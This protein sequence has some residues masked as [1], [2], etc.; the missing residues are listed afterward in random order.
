MTTTPATGVEIRGQG[1]GER[2][3]QLG[4]RCSLSTHLL[5]RPHTLG[6]LFVLHRLGIFPRGMLS[7]M[8]ALGLT[9]I[10]RV[11]NSDTHIQQKGLVQSLL[12]R[13]NSLRS[14]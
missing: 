6:S 4:Q 7:T 11:C 14:Q 5:M 3:P 10:H 9:H 8:P 1:P 13:L 2:A 12:C